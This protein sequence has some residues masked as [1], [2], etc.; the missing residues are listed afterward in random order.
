MR[1]KQSPGGS[2]VPSR[3]FAALERDGDF[4]RLAIAYLIDEAGVIANDVAAGV[5]P[6]LAL[7]N[8]A[9]LRTPEPE[10]AMR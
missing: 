4:H 3:V 1:N 7:L 8:R 2:P 6:I 5:E 10:L 9:T